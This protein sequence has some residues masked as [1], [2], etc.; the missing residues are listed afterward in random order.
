M[1]TALD[2]AGLGGTLQH[3]NPL[4]DLKV[5]ERYLIPNDWQLKG[6]LVFGKI[7][8]PPAHKEKMFKPLQDRV[9]VHGASV[10]GNDQQVDQEVPIL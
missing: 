2:Q 9:I 7:S 6:Q 5:A 1:W 3:Y 10:D 4:I 8:G